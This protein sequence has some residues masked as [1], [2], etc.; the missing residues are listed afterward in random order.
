MRS[1]RGDYAAVP[2]RMDAAAIERLR[3]MIAL[4]LSDRGMSYRAVA[5]VIGTSRSDV[6]RRLK[7]MPADVKARCRRTGLDG[8]I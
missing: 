7:G 6:H 3:D 1:L 8:L 5:R 4:A 2:E